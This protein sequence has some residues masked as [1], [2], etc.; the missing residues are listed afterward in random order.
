MSLNLPDVK[1]WNSC[2]LF[3]FKSYQSWFRRLQFS[4]CLWG[5]LNKLQPVKLLLFFSNCCPW[6]SGTWLEICRFITIC[7]AA[8]QCVVCIVQRSKL[9]LKLCMHDNNRTA[10]FEKELNHNQESYLLFH[11]CASTKTSLP[12]LLQIEIWPPL[13]S[14]MGPKPLWSSIIH[15]WNMQKHE[16]VPRVVF[17]PKLQSWNLLISIFFQRHSRSSCQKSY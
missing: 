8:A 10:T 2:N 4:F 15:F 3:N 7:Y 11:R 14:T 16:T 6:I 17:F 9:K 1:K 13:M 12:R 5:Q